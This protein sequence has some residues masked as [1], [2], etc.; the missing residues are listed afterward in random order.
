MRMVRNGVVVDFGYVNGIPATISFNGNTFYYITN[1][2]GDI[3]GITDTQGN[4]LI[5]YY[6]DAWGT[7]YCTYNTATSPYAQSLYDLNPL[8]Y[9]GYVFDR[10]A[11]MYYLQTRYYIPSIGRFLNADGLVST[12]QGILGNNMFAYCEN[13]PITR[14]DPTGYLSVV[15]IGGFIVGVIG[16]VVVG[17]GI[18]VIEGLEAAFDLLST[19]IVGDGSSQIYLDGS[20]IVEALQDSPKMDGH[21]QNAINRYES[22]GA[23]AYYGTDEFTPTEDGANLYLSTQHFSY[24]I[25]VTTEKRF[26]G[27]WDQNCKQERTVATVYVYDTYDF[28]PKAWNGIGNVL[29]NLA[30][31]LNYYGG[32]GNDYYWCAAYSYKCE[33]RLCG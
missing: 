17:A 6:Y 11:G 4:V 2:Q 32:T 14:S 30:Y 25:A 27:F 16:G 5:T 15:S 1:G 31:Y 23:A 24:F 22:G 19:W 26:R 13:N 12:G 3:T 10:E 21:I 20:P 18:E 9:R 29:N 8:L 7:A 33:W 28:D